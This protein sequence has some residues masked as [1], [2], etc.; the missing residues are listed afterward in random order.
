MSI[1][2]SKDLLGCTDRHDY[3]G[4][5]QTT[6]YQMASVRNKFLIGLTKRLLKPKAT[7]TK[8]IVV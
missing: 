7:S 3:I 1:K 6:P 8:T 5:I 2:R 4:S